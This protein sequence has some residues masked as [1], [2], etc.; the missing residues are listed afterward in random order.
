MADKKIQI[1]TFSGDNA[2]PVTKLENITMTAGPGLQVSGNTIGCAIAVAG[3]T[4]TATAGVVKPNSTYFSTDAN[5]FLTPKTATTSALG[6]CKFSSTYF[7]V[8][9][10]SVS[11]KVASTSQKGV[12]QLAT[13]AEATTG[14][15]TE[16]ARPHLLPRAPPTQPPPPMPLW[17]VPPGPSGGLAVLRAL[18]PTPHGGKHIPHCVTS[19]H[20][21]PRGPDHSPPPLPSLLTVYS[22]FLP[23]PRPARTPTQLPH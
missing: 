2:F 17:P 21:L 16:K 6:V 4:A 10:G 18:P 12:V 15:N 1:K 23:A 8:S 13:T 20:G 9:S 7:T 14:T 11:P 3:T 19:L 22:H 5:G